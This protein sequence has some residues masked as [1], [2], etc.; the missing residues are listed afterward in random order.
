MKIFR[1]K[2]LLGPLAIA[3]VSLTV[4]Q[5]CSQLGGG[6]DMFSPAN[7]T[8]SSTTLADIDHPASKTATQNIQKMQVA[9]RGYV[10]QLLRENF[11]S[12]MTPVPGL[13]SLLLKWVG[14]R[15]A[16]FGL[17]CD[18][19]SSYTGQDC[20]GDISAANLPYT[21]DDNTIRQSFRVQACDNI[22]GY[23]QAVTAILEKIKVDSLAPNA[24]GIRQI[25]LLFY[26]AESTVPEE[27]VSALVAMDRELAIAG[28]TPVDRWRTVISQICISPGWQSL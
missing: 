1:W 26:R 11:S 28:E 15:D 10:A 7:L 12:D 3:V 2:S 16:Q 18:P 14:S 6:F 23:D 19:Y 9:N 17:G 8:M 4:Y 27:I 24:N 5:N 20:G 22:L 25:Y 21:A 13:E